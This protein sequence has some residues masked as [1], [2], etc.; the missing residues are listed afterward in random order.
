MSGSS[1]FDSFRVFFL[2]SHHVLCP[3]VYF[4]AKLELHLGH[5]NPF[6]SCKHFRMQA[7]MP[8]PQLSLRYKVKLPIAPIITEFFFYF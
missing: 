5:L 7:K 8:Q 4:S 1:N 6:Q 3:L 2:L